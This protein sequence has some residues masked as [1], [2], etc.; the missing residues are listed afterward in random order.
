MYWFCNGVC[1][2]R[3]VSNIWGSKNTPI[4]ENSSVFYGKRVNVV[5]NFGGSTFIIPSSFRMRL[6]K[7][8]KW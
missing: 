6:E 4:F 8:K 2:F 7:Q 5:G 3:F 1:F